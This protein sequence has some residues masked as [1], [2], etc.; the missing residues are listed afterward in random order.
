MEDIDDEYED[1]R[2]DHYDNL[3]ERKYLTLDGARDRALKI[4]WSD[5]QA[6]K[7]TFLG[8]KVFH[9]VP[10]P[11]LI[12]YIDWKGFFDTW[13]IRGR[14]PNGRF[15]KIFNDPTVGTLSLIHIKLTRIQDYQYF[16]GILHITVKNFVYFDQALKLKSY[17]MKRKTC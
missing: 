5:F 7:P 8:T 9:D 6:T 13:E 4:D 14:Y 15:P 12:P 11:K 3:L 16:V 17:T 10:I 2:Q 1:I